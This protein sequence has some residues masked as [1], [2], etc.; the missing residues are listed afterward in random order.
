[1][2]A[3]RL[4]AMTAADEVGFARYKMTGFQRFEFVAV[5]GAEHEAR[6]GFP[7]VLEPAGV[8]VFV[9]GGLPP[10]AGGVPDDLGDRESFGGRVKHIADEDAQFRLGV[11]HDVGFDIFGEFRVPLVLARLF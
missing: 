11:F 10:R 4:V 3:T 9:G 7:V 1:M 5:R 8:A 2:P 6:S